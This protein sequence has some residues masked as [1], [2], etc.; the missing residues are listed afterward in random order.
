ME[1]KVLDIVTYEDRS[2]PRTAYVVTRIIDS[3]WGRQ[4]GL[5]NIE[6]DEYVVSDLRQQ[7]WKYQM[8]AAA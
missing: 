1:A 6:T 5:L 3:Q 2:N 7:G 8:S 4:Y